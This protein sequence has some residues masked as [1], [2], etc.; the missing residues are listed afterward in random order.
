MHN[1]DTPVGRLLTRREILALLG[2]AGAALA[3]APPLRRGPLLLHDGTRIPAC[4]VRPAQMEGP[5]FVDT[6]LNRSDIRSDPGSGQV[7]GGLPFDLTLNVSKMSGAS[8][9]PL[10]GVLVDIWQCDADGVYS[11]VKDTDGLF[12]TRG[13][14]FLRGHQITDAQGRARFTTIYPGWYPGRTVHIHFKLRTQPNAARGE[15]FTSQLYFEDSVS[16]RIFTRE[17]YRSHTGR[18]TLNQADGIFRDG[19]Q[20][21]MVAVTESGSALAGSFDVAF[22]A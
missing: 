6:K 10:A 2:G 16:D 13:K 3:I 7:P 20:E 1:D 21:L 4:V 22:Q 5:Y 19:G 9:A 17:P 12:D 18:R 14:S 15:E 11:G 8:C